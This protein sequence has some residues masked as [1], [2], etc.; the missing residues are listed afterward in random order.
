MFDKV[1]K[2]NELRKEA[3][4]LKKE[5]AAEIIEVDRGNIKVVISADIKIHSLD[6]PS[7]TDAKDLTEA[8][9][10]AVEEVQKI[11]AK[12]MQSQMGAL[13]DLLG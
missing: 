12:K 6:Y 9:N 10:K 3:D 5:L 7:N 2:I 8:I 13:K 11:A 4:T 1:R